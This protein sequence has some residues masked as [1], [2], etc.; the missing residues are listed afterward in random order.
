MKFIRVLLPVVFVAAVL[1]ACGPNPPPGPPSAGTFT[2]A[3][4]AS[5]VTDV[6]A[7]M[8]AFL[9]SVPDG[10]TVTLRAGGQYRMEQTFSIAG[11]RG[12]T[13]RGNGATFEFTTAG[14]RSTAENI[15]STRARPNV[16]IVNSA[17]ITVSGLNVVG[18]NPMA[19]MGEAA[20]RSEYEAQHGFDV[21]NSARISLIGCSATDTYGDFIYIGGGFAGTSRSTDVLVRSF[22]GL[23]SGRQGITFT[24]A[25]RVVVE[26]ST[27]SE[28]RRSTF[29][30]EPESEAASVD[31]VT[32]RNNRVIGGR[33]N[34]VA[35]H[36]RGPINHV[37]VQGNRLSGQALSVTVFDLDGG[38]RSDWTVLDNSS[39]Y[40]AGNPALAVMSFTRVDGVRVQ[41][42][43]QLMSLRGG[44]GGPQ[45][46]MYLVKATDTTG[47]VVAGNTV[48]NGA[49]ELQP[50]PG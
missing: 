46:L 45:P 34:F 13:I 8:A 40:G 4:D 35:A 14:D 32:L 29:D 3:V 15:K 42:N 26:Q 10:S 7:P 41:G 23:R 16:R 12:L 25:S 28:V 43:R 17:D 30:F 48:I 38:R 2:P 47:I 5:G 11:R 1:A 21:L 36:G 19:G 9:A 18:A 22:T 49:G 6:S 37:T 31:N 50:A 27:L 44:A 20:Y 33:L 39:D 24:E